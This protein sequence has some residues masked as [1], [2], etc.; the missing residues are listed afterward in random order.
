MPLGLREKLKMRNDMK[1]VVKDELARHREDIEKSTYKYYKTV[2]KDTR[3]IIDE[4]VAKLKEQIKN[5]LDKR[6]D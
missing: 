5:E 2:Q 1:Q 3:I 6:S 4:E